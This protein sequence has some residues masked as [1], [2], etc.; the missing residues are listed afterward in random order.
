M[1]LRES[2]GLYIVHLGESGNIPGLTGNLPWET[3]KTG[4]NVVVLR[5][6]PTDI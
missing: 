3:D 5:R 4:E 1:R 6:L 2:W